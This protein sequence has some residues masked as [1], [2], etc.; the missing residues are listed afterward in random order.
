MRFFV[1][2]QELQAERDLAVT[3]AHLA[4]WK[5]GRNVGLDAGAE[6]FETA[7]A[8]LAEFDPRIAKVLAS[9]ARTL[10]GLK[11]PP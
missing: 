5:E 4:A 9:A 1:T 2:E 3:R 6:M 7:V 10:R 11:T 8:S